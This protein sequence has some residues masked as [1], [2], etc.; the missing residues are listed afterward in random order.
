MNIRPIPEWTLYRLRFAIGYGV[1]VVLAVMLLALNV[2]L[3]PGISPGEQQSVISAHAITFTQLPGEI[4]DL[5]YH[6]LQKLSVEWLGVSPYGVR[7]PSIAIGLVTA[8]CMT[9]LLRRWFT[10]NV[11][12][13]ASVILITSTWFLA[14]ARLGTP[15][16]M[17]P[18]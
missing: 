10:R 3:A 16:I 6:A 4:I 12:I 11:A 8:L 15:A 14:T 13:M 5:P 18:F 7:L 17:I 9:L 2:D 1:L